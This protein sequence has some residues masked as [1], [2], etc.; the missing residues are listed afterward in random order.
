MLGAVVAAVPTPTWCPTAPSCRCSIAVPIVAVAT[1]GILWTRRRPRH[2]R[3]IWRQRRG[4]HRFPEAVLIAHPSERPLLDQ[5]AVVTPALVSEA[6]GVVDETVAVETVEP[7]D[8]A[9]RPPRPPRPPAPPP[10]PRAPPAS[11]RTVGERFPV[12]SDGIACPRGAAGAAGRRRRPG[13]ADPGGVRRR[14]QQKHDAAASRTDPL[15]GTVLPAAQQ[16]VI[17]A[18]ALA[19]LRCSDLADRAEAS[20]A[21]AAAAGELGLTP[22]DERWASRR[23]GPDRGHRRQ[24]GRQGVPAADRGVDPPRRRGRGGADARPDHVE[25]PT[26]TTTAAVT[27]TTTDPAPQVLIAQAPAG[28]GRHVAD[29][30]P[31]SCSAR[32]GDITEV[33]L[34]PE[35]DDVIV[36]WSGCCLPFANVRVQ[37]H[38]G[39]VTAVRTFNLSAKRP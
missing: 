19:P 36:V 7:A 31:A 21:V 22:D 38:N 27:T 11:A 4:I 2:V 13:P 1:V 8:P 32:P 23:S 37:V 26:T 15:D 35:E 16:S 33:G 28:P 34:S 10:A 39:T 29:R 14:R 30:G 17:D 9:P 12:S 6:P 24:P 25:P 20:A 3:P 18:L 5:P